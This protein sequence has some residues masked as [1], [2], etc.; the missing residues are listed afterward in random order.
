MHADDRPAD[1]RAPA[2][3]LMLVTRDRSFRRLGVGR[4]GRDS[5][6]RELPFRGGVMSDGVLRHVPANGAHRAGVTKRAR[7]S[8]DRYDRCH[9]R[10]EDELGAVSADTSKYVRRNG[11]RGTTGTNFIP[12]PELDD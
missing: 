12:G 5:A 1:E 4:G 2:T 8:S 10:G 6:P 11:E 3:D 7:G 9:K